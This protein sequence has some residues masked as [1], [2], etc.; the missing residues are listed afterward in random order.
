MLNCFSVSVALV[1]LL[2]ACSGHETTPPSLTPP[3]S[4][5]TDVSSE[6]TPDTR[7]EQAPDTGPATDITPDALAPARRD[8]APL[9]P[10]VIG[11]PLSL[12]GVLYAGAAAVDI[13]PDP[14]AETVYLAGF[15]INRVATGVRDPIWARA[16]VLARDRE[17]IAIV[18]VDL[19]GMTGYRA[20]RAASRLAGDGFA[21]ERLIV[22]ATHNHSGPDTIGKW[23]PS[24]NESG[25][26]LEYQER[27]EAGIEQAVREAAGDM[28]PATA[29]AGARQTRE[30][31][32][33]FTSARF[34]GKLE[35]NHSIIGLIRDTRDPVVVDD[36]LTA[37]GVFDAASGKAI[38]T[39]LHVNTHMEAAGAKTLLTSDFA[40]AAREVLEAHFEGVGLVWVGAV[41]GL[42]NPLGVNMPETDAAGAIQWRECGEAATTD[43]S[44]LQCFGLA[45]GDLRLD[46]DGDPVPRW[47]TGDR[48]ELTDSYG[49]LLAGVARDLIEHA[50]EDSDPALTVQS[51]P[52]LL[53]LENRFFEI[54]GLELDPTLLDP[55]TNFATEFFPEHVDELEQM[56]ETFA[57]AIFDFPGSWIVT[58]ERCPG[59]ETPRV[60][61]CLPVMIWIV[62]I[63]PLHLL[64][65]PGELFP[66]LSIGLPP[67]AMAE[68][69]DATLRGEGAVFFRQHDR[70]CDEVDWARCRDAVMVDDCDCRL[71]HATPYE[72]SAEEDGAPLLSYL[73]G[74]Y[75]IALG[76][77]GD[78]L[79]YIMPESDFL[80]LVTRPMNRLLSPGIL[81]V[82]EYASDPRDHYEELVSLGPSMAPLIER[83]VRDMLS[84]ED[85]NEECK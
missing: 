73:D 52:L 39:L 46:A 15:G 7:H 77:G 85:S 54:S 81:D 61:S 20:Q 11:I 55:L 6:Q 22:H 28:R 79:G 44:D 49:R 2:Q 31:S 75:R 9:P 16:L 57:A 74:P 35:T 30:L 40:H 34:G 41:G 19:V 25:L 78:M 10:E 23:G 47:V 83:A 38:A 17:Y 68:A 33:Y 18:A 13:T 67:E 1:L 62:R 53:P 59:I 42:Q 29:R 27:L 58:D 50:E 45:P 76:L 4:H 24:R 36:Q 80:T 72:L 26:S 65:V 5:S 60:T 3:P 37:L 8:T 71:Y 63:G 51:T 12:D 32:P 48:F 69:A 43:E 64:T 14:E 84:A 21:Q 70:A 56:R 82:V 66:E